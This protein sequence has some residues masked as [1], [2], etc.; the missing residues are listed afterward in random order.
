MDKINVIREMNRLKGFTQMKAMCIERHREIKGH[1]MGENEFLPNYTPEVPSDLVDQINEFS[2]P[3][4][5]QARPCHWR[6][7]K[8][9]EPDTKK[10]ARPKVI[11]VQN[12][13]AGW[14]QKR[15]Q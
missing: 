4:Q 13:V 3:V 2:Q 1:A 5:I 10:P 6:D 12:L 8:G 9:P 11:S 15:G 7:V 14:W